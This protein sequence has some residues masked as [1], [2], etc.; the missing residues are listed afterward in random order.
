MRTW[1]RVKIVAFAMMMEKP[2][3]NG[4]SLDRLPLHSFLFPLP[5]SFTP[6]NFL[7]L[8]TSPSL[9]L[10]ATAFGF[11]K[12]PT[13]K[14]NREE[15]N[16][17][18]YKSHAPLVSW[19]PLFRG[20]Q[21]W[22]WKVIQALWAD[23][24]DHYQKRVWICGTARWQRRQSCYSRLAWNATPRVQVRKWGS[25]SSIH[26]YIHP[27]LFIHSFAFMITCSAV[28]L[29]WPWHQCSNFFLSMLSP[30]GYCSKGGHRVCY[31]Q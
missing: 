24:R 28:I 30:H 16:K 3:I 29:V 27:S 4:S 25:P 11:D 18:T 22:H 14:Q 10:P 2:P 17:Q 23:S 1:T 5:L 19:K 20:E 8:S 7:S 15:S 9:S 31:V 6:Y 13:T 12:H 26:S 21:P